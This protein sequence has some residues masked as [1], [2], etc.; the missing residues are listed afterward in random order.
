MTAG[1]QARLSSC[2][3]PPCEVGPVPEEGLSPTE[4]HTP[5]N[6]DSTGL[7]CRCPLL[8]TVN[9][10][11]LLKTGGVGSQ[12]PFLMTPGSPSQLLSGHRVGDALGRHREWTEAGGVRQSSVAEEGAH[13]SE[14][15][16]GWC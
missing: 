11:H 1:S 5:L 8:E 4:P 10:T 15:G 9:N 13:L 12:T 2:C 6:E 7:R 14:E 16:P 3:P